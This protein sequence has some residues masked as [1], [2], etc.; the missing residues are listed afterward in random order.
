MTRPMIR[1]FTLRLICSLFILIF[2]LLFQFFLDKY[3][4]IF[5]GENLLVV[6]LASF[7]LFFP[8]HRIMQRI[9]RRYF[10]SNLYDVQKVIKTLSQQLIDVVD[11]ERVISLVSETLIDCMKL[12]KA[13][14]LIKEEEQVQ[15]FVGFYEKKKISLSKDNFLV[16]Q[17]ERTQG[18][19]IYKDISRKI[20]KSKDSRK[21]EELIRL[22]NE[23]DRRGINLSL[24]L[25]REGKLVGFFI[26]GK[27]ILGDAYFREDLE[28]LKIIA[29]QLVLVLGKT[30]LYEEIKESVR[31]KEKL[32]QILL[33]INS[34]LDISKILQLIVNTAIEFTVSQR[35][36]LIIL[37]K[38]K[39]IHQAAMAASE[40]IFSYPVKEPEFDDVVWR[41]IQEKKPVLARINSFGS[42]DSLSRKKKKEKVRIVAGF[43]LIAE[44]KVMG[45][46]IASSTFPSGFR[47]DDIQILSLLADQASIAISKAQLIEDLRKAKTKLQSWNKELEQKV[48]KKTEQLQH[49][50][51]IIFQSEKLA[52]I[53]QLA[54]GMAHE[55]RN[56]LGIITTSLY[57]L[58]EILPD[59]RKD[60]ERHF[61]I[62]ESEIERCQL[63]INNLLEFSR[64]SKSEVEAIDVNR[65]LSITL[66]LVEKDLFTRDIRLMKKMV[67]RPKI[68]ANLDEMK[69]VFLNLIMNAAQAMPTGGELKIT[70]FVDRNN[71]VKV[72]IADTGVGIPRKNLN[73]IFD[74]FFTTKAAGEGTGLGLTIVHTIVKR[75]E[76]VIDV[77]SEEGKGS[78]FTLEFP[79]FET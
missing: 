25:L 17:L 75:Y 19:V 18:P 33:S 55:I 9:G 31:E 20:R 10:P 29:N 77:K 8:L 30:K 44:K 40:P 23:M 37:D 22:K 50:Q 45:A 12:E 56:P 2:A 7:A 48:K 54:A 41:I 14:I 21:K 59:K 57:Y 52:S 74:P 42:S 78:I 51:N 15:K 66:S 72:E 49:S 32:R 70:T 13:G 34:F 43:P 53:G 39:K 3:F 62:I 36:V 71:K 58:N 67:G 68:K 79:I 60:V 63:L 28:L 6:F 73:R 64:K 16:R 11:L 1:K 27:K 5:L 65:L 69:E 76:G 26:L 47:K 24:P 38:K 4:S 35:S 61:Q 46:L